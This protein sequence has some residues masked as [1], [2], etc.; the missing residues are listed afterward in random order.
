MLYDITARKAAETALSVARVQLA[1]HTVQL[2]SLV[3]RRTAQ[4]TASNRQLETSLRTVRRGEA[5]NRAHLVESHVMQK[6]LRHL[7]HQILSTQEEERKKISREL[8]DEVVQTLVGIN[9]ELSALVH[10]N[11]PEARHLKDKIA[12]TQRLVENSVNAVHSFARELRP[13]V[14]DDLGLIPALHAYCK[15]LAARKKLKIQLT[16]FGAVEKLRATSAPCCS[17]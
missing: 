15:S 12:H 7:T 8:H 3:G 2:E 17:A 14:L 6:K 13:A 9:V 10:G 5:E 16:A 4:L 11:S 1:A